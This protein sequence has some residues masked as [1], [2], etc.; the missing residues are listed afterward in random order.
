MFSTI[1]KKVKKIY[2]DLSF[3]NAVHGDIKWY[4]GVAYVLR[5]K[6]QYNGWY[7]A[8]TGKKLNAAYGVNL[9]EI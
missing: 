3:G 2:V 1:V 9:Y 8:L 7:S 4:N 5:T 6:S